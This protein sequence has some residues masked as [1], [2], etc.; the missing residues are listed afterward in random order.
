MRICE[1]GNM[2]VVKRRRRILETLKIRR[3]KGDEEYL[4]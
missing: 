2:D 1:W 3:V 4:Y